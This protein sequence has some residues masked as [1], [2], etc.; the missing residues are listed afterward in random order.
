M[1]LIVWLY[2]ILY[3]AIGEKIKQQKIQLYLRSMSQQSTNG[4]VP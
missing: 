2:V 1:I 3:I 4:A